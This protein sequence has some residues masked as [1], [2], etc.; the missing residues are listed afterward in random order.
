MM[1]SNLLDVFMTI[2]KRDLSLGLSRSSEIA[3]PLIFFFIVVMIFPFALGPES[4]LL[5]RIMPGVIWI[6]VLLSATL[7]L[8]MMFRSD[9]E[10]GSLE[11]MLLSRYPMTL[12]IMAKIT[13]HWLLTG[14]PL[15]LASIFL[16]VLLN[17][18]VES[19]LYLFITMMLGTPV[20]SM[21]GSAVMALTVGLRGGGVLLALL[22]L[23][24]YI[25]V[26]IFSIAAID[27]AILGL[28]ITGEIYILGALLVLAITLA[29]FATST[30]LRI[31]FG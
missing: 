31:R 15:I 28:P 23:P 19:L 21:V 13:A 26:L 12:L 7:S 5:Q 3:N 29:P 2:L 27:N 20:L 6:A 24:L 10:D 30:S 9:F 16:G 14:A 22:I 1:K 25:P 17:L 11:L 18:P 4:N 8:D